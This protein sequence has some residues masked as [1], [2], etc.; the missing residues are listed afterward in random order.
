MG[1]LRDEL[2]KLS[3]SDAVRIL[4]K[5]GEVKVEPYEPLTED[6]I[7]DFD[8]MNLDGMNADDLEFLLDRVEDLLDEMEEE[9]PEDEDSEEHDL[10]EDRISEIEDFMDRIRDRLDELEE[11]EEN[12]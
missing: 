5:S 10:W 6:D 4:F 12:D 9:E 7:D 2:K 11:E 3:D 1:N 8:S